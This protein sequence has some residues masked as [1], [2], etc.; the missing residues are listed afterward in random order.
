[1]IFS[2]AESSMAETEL[3]EV[4]TAIVP[5]NNHAPQNAEKSTNKHRQQAPTQPVNTCTGTTQPS[6]PV[7]KGHGGA[8]P[9]EKRSNQCNK[10]RRD[11]SKAK[12]CQ[13]YLSEKA[14]TL[15][16]GIISKEGHAGKNHKQWRK[17]AQKGIMDTL[18][19]RRG[20]L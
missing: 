15:W 10:C 3:S 11:H 12:D 7:Q 6:V 2:L 1:M 13:S 17:Q 14:C 8:R 20:K 4:E 9:K 16:V 5:L 18:K 19:K